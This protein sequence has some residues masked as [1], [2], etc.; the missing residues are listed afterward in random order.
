MTISSIKKTKGSR[1]TDIFLTFHYALLRAS[2]RLTASVQIRRFKVGK[3]FA[4]FIITLAAGHPTFALYQEYQ[5]AGSI[6]SGGGYSFATGQ[7]RLYAN[8]ALLKKDFLGFEYDLDSL[9]ADYG[10][11]FSDYFR[12]GISGKAHIFD[13]QNLNHI[14]DSSTGEELKPVSL[15]SP[16]YRGQGYA[17]LRYQNLALRYAAGAQKYYLSKRDTV[18]STLTVEAPGAMFVH[19][20]ALGYWDIRQ[21]KPYAFRGMAA[22][23]SVEEHRLSSLYMWQ[24][25]GTNISQSRSQV[26]IHELHVRAGTQL[27]GDSVKLMAALRAGATNFALPGEAQD[28]IESFS[29]GGP[30]NRY[31][32]LAGYAFSEFR[33]PAFGIINLDAV[34]R[35]GGPVNLWLVADAATFDREYNSRRLHAGAGAGL[36]VELPDGVLGGRSAF[37]SRIE[38]PFFAAGSGR[39]QIFLG[40]NGQIF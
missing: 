13:Y 37:F 21:I 18:N 26:M 33:V 36:I 24:A 34:I 31:R 38:V 30:E 4:L 12:I 7:Y 27:A 20:A 10:Y 6:A 32:R 3:L 8:Q 22:Y 15:N 17:E 23:L 9:Y 35:M 2:A 39:F 1:N 40:L 19:N 16:F 14:V 25:A 5:L 11:G 28:I 29:I